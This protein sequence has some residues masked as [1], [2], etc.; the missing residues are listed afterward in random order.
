MDIAHHQSDFEGWLH[1]F[2]QGVALKGMPTSLPASPSVARV[3]DLLLNKYYL[4]PLEA[5]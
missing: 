1:T 3:C 4:S 5:L 2:F